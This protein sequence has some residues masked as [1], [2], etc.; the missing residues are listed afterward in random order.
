MVSRQITNYYTKR[1]KYKNKQGY[2]ISDNPSGWGTI[3]P[4]LTS[5]IS[6]YR[7]FLTL[8]QISQKCWP[9]D[10]QSDRRQT[11]WG[12]EMTGH[13]KIIQLQTWQ[14]K[15][16]GCHCLPKMIFQLTNV[17]ENLVKSTVYLHQQGKCSL[18]NKLLHL[19]HSC[20]NLFTKCWS[21]FFGI[22][23]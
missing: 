8:C 19:G 20:K 18:E 17:Y 22:G 11:R 10:R 2:T 12:I 5:F 14:N 21:W 7:Q 16:L 15:N 3:I 9:T 4:S 1:T 23:L 13:F 6:V